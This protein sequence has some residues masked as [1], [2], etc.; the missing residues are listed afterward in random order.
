VKLSISFNCLSNLRL[1]NLGLCIMVVPFFLLGR[2]IWKTATF[3]RTS[4]S[5]HSSLRF[6]IVCVSFF[7]QHKQ[8]RKTSIFT[9]CEV[10]K[11]ELNNHLTAYSFLFVFTVNPSKKNKCKYYCF[12]RDAIFLF[13]CLHLH[14]FSL[15]GL[16]NVNQ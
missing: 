12:F 8:Q 11:Q 9:T 7:F 14:F 2:C 15:F 5:L 13:F 1:I 10:C 4:L 16:S 6:E 3:F